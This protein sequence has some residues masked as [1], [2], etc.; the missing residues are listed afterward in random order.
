MFGYMTD[1]ETVEVKGTEEI[2]AEG[3]DLESLLFHFLDEFLFLFS[4]DPY[5]IPRRVEI[6]EFDKQSFRIKAIGHGETFDL[7]KHPQGTEVK[8]ITYSNLQVYDTADKHEV[9][10]IVDI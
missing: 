6:T 8:A 10:V 3:D 5:F 4:A 1:I 7:S 2:T 9:Y